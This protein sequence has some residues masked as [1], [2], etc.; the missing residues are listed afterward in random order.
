M[1][2]FSLLLIFSACISLF[3]IGLHIVMGEGMLLHFIRK[4]YDRNYDKLEVITNEIKSGF[5]NKDGEYWRR[6]IIEV[7]LK[8]VIGCVVCYSSFWTIVWHGLY[9]GFGE[10]YP[11]IHEMFIVAAFNAILVGLYDRL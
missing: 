5:R 4:P 6:T 8:P 2:G 7:L 11:L 10:L 1:I 9:F 3:C